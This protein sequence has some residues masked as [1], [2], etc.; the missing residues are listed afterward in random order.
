MQA[1]GRNL[2]NPYRGIRRAVFGHFASPEYAALLPGLFNYLFLLC[3][4]LSAQA[5]HRAHLGIESRD[6]G[7]GDAIAEID[8]P[9]FPAFG[10]V[11]GDP[12]E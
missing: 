3:F 4:L 11:G 2:G 5:A 10:G 1:K 9:V 6:F 12:V 8:D 7:H